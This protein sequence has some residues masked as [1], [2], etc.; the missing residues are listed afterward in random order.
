MWSSR[1]NQFASAR[2]QVTKVEDTATICKQAQD[3]SENEEGFTRDRKTEFALFV[4]K[5]TSRIR[6]GILTI[7]T[8]CSSTPLPT[9]GTSSEDFTNLLILRVRKRFRNFVGFLTKQ[10]FSS[11]YYPS[12]GHYVQHK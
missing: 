9:G 11:S 8:I 3:L 7:K 5:M 10:N 2:K 12:P 4:A 1:M 6:K